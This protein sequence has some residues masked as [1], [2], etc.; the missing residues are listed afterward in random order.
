[1]PE[2]VPMTPIAHIRSPFETKFGVP[3]QSGLVPELTAEIVFTPPYRNPDALRGIEGFDYIWLLWHF[4]AARQEGWSPTVRPPRLGG[5]AR[6]GVFATRSPFRP[7][8]IGLSCVRLLGVS[9]DSRGPVLRVAG[10]DLMDGTPIFDIK[11]YLPYADAHP[12]AAGGFT[13]EVSRRQLEVEIPAA[14]L[15]Q[16]PEA[17]RAALTGVLAQ[18]PRPSYQS[19]PSR[20]YGMRFAGLEVRFT[21]DGDRL[22]V[23]A[24]FPAEEMSKEKP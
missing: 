5:N 7:N 2:T 15:A 13:A 3:R 14:L 8:P 10:A 18:D 11:P 22:R 19:D 1:M 17:S 24:V 20:I 16:I 4:S 9:H 21:V 23:E 12:E 6:L